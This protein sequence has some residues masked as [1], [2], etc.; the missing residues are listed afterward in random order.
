MKSEVLIIGAGLTGLLLAHRLKKHGI[1]VKIV[2]ARNRI[3]GRIHTIVSHNETPIEMG[4]TWLGVQHQELVQ[5]LQELEL[6]IFEQFMTGKA[7]FESLSTA[8]PQ[9]FDIPNNQQPSYRIQNGTETITN[10]LAESLDKED[11]I[12]DET[13]NRIDFSEK[14]IIIYTKKES[15]LANKVVS[16]LPPMLLVNSI[17]FTP[18]LPSDL[19][20][21]ANK[22]HTWMGAS[23][24]FGISYAK[25]FWK[26]L[27]FSG[28]VFSNVGPITELY[29]HSNYQN[30]RFALKGFLQN[31]MYA[32]TKENRKSKVF[33]QLK[34]LFGDP[35]LDYLSYEETIWKNEPYTSI[36]SDQ[37]I[38]PHQNNGHEIY[39]Q[40][41][42][43][44]RLFVA[45]TETS[46][47]FGGYM[48]GAIRSAQSI[49]QKLI[50]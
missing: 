38:F 37:F 46:V 34:K 16:T 10:K 44:N 32:E 35:A 42:Y 2:E 3:G 6:P 43:D 26:E 36:L 4:A 12:L 22:T 20:T 9:R 13:V 19:A 29:D 33:Q 15:Y 17:G 27:N 48:E 28:T 18:T 5:L 30:D 8:P 40:A 7:L 45:G 24:K 1:S 50:Q 41:F 39:Q 31:E 49:Y 25:P 14:N 11:I 21:I 23:I 47:Q